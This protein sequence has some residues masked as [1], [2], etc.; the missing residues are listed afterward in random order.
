MRAR[1]FIWRDEAYSF[2]YSVAWPSAEIAVMGAEGA[3]KV[4]FRNRPDQDK[5][6]AEYKEKFTTPLAAARKGYLDDIIEP[7]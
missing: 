5:L 1:R 3:V 7:R 4:I 2:M 6:Q